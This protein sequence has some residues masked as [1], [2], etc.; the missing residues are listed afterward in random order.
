MKTSHI[1]AVLFILAWG[2][3]VRSQDL[4]T[5]Q[6]RD[7]IQNFMY[8]TGQSDRPGV[9]LAESQIE[10]HH[11]IKCGTPFIL[12]FFQNYDRLDR[13]LLASMGAQAD[14]TPPV[15][16]YTYGSPQGH[17]LLH[18]NKTGSSACWQANVD[19]DGD[20]VPNYIERLADIADSCY[21]FEF[22]TLGM[23]L[24]EPD[25]ICLPGGDNRI[26]IYMLGLPGG[27][28]GLTYPQWEC[29]D[30]VSPSDPCT[31]PSWIWIDNDFQELPDYVGNPIPAAQVTIAHEM[32]HTSHFA[33]DGCEHP[34]WFEMSAVWM[35]EQ[36]Y[37]DVND[38]KLYDYVFFESPA[39][40]LCD[41]FNNHQYQSVV[42]PIYLTE[43]YGRNVVKEIW[44][45]SAALGYAWDFLRATDSV[46]RW[47][48]DSV[49]N[50]Q[51]RCSQYSGDLT[52]CLDSVVVPQNLTTALTEFEVWN[53]F[54][55]P[56]ASQ[57]PNGMTYSEAASYDHV[58]IDKMAV[59]RVYPAIVAGD[60]NH[61]S[62]E[63]DG[64]MY[65][66][67]DNLGAIE[68]DTLG[69]FPDSL[70][71][72]YIS[73]A[74]TLH[75][76]WGIGGMFQMRDIPDSFVVIMNTIPYWSWVDSSFVPPRKFRGR[77]LEHLLGQWVKTSVTDSAQVLN[78][79][80]F[81]TA[82]FVFVPA[83]PLNVYYDIRDTLGISYQ[84]N[85]SSSIDQAR[86]N[87]PS[88]V[89]TPYPN[90]AV[91]DRMQGDDLHFRFQ[92]PTDQTSFPTYSTVYLTVDVF[93]IAGERVRT[94]EM[95]TESEGRGDSQLTGVY[96][97]G[98]DM[99][100]EGGKDVASGVYLAVARLFDNADKDTQLAEDRVKV[101]VIR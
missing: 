85:N 77:Y 79:K 52:E 84:V 6:Q 3:A 27:Y 18:Y 2:S 19:S 55:G 96:E 99:K 5:E 24:P 86:I 63:P 62:P 42:W 41:T 36:K 46:I 90:P 28:Y 7:I 38:Y 59:Q 75:L 82:T 12:E 20:G 32:Y 56:Y 47:E 33:T 78:V 76:N 87:L 1:L 16:Q 15:T 50:W 101:A 13:R 74:D 49:Q 44:L 89:L 93:T 71:S 10:N 21:V 9:S 26:D 94:I 35:E 22:D 83:W 40:S 48:S 39:T 58:P 17:V 98:W 43:K 64:A 69:L 92:L 95:S 25:S 72:G 66:R 80:R 91:V 11:P 81:S 45:E 14:I 57:A 30:I 73:A 31:A 51:Y 70:L 97:I 4:T 65:L 88:G 37:D 34:A 61:F 100:N 60:T 8:V 67:L 53:F 29:G 68:E 54:T 23:P